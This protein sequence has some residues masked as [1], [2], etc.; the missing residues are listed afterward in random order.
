MSNE[1]SPVA[2][3]QNIVLAPCPFCE[4]PHTQL[5]IGVDG[6]AFGA[7]CQSCYANGPTGYNADD[8]VMFT[9]QEIADRWNAAANAAASWRWIQQVVGKT[10]CI[11]FGGR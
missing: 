1:S 10:G 8:S 7:E 11:D 3:V 4:S 9:P 5:M 2:P 6:V